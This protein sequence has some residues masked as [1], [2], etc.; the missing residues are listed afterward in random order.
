MPVR[1][2]MAAG[3][4]LA[5]ACCRHAGVASSR[6]L[7]VRGIARAALTVVRTSAAL[8]AS[9]TRTG[10]I[11]GSF[12]AL[13]LKR[14]PASSRE[15]RLA[16]LCRSLCVSAPFAALHSD[17]GAASSVCLT[18][19]IAFTMS[20]PPLAFCPALGGC[21]RWIYLVCPCMLRHGCMLLERER[22]TRST[23]G[24]KWRLTRYRASRRRPVRC[25]PA[26]R[27]PLSARCSRLILLAAP[28]IGSP[29][30]PFLYIALCCLLRCC[31][32]FLS[33]G[34]C[35]SE[36]SSSNACSGTTAL[37][38]TAC[39]LL[40]PPRAP[41]SP[42]PVTVGVLGRRLGERA[43][44]A[45]DAGVDSI[46]AS[47]CVLRRGWSSVNLRASGETVV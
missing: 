37:P 33:R 35:A 12:A 14:C 30:S 44:V 6:A 27:H 9:S 8:P 46:V 42:V 16:V 34:D 26:V 18:A 20:Y 45:G 28:R 38:V 32:L 3:V 47:A 41:L 40:T 36:E 7:A 29:I 43:R 17:A 15:T 2:S 22:R 1:L 25:L 13:F 11:T 31:S 4:L 21:A 24:R 23:A 39:S 5:L 10:A 19:F